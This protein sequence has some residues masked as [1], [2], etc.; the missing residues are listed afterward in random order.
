MVWQYVFLPKMFHWLISS[1]AFLEMLQKKKYETSSFRH[2]RRGPF[3]PYVGVSHEPLVSIDYNG[4]QNSATI[5][6]AMTSVMADRMVKVIAWYDNESGYSKRVVD[7]V[8]Y[9]AEKALS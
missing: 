1:L 5:D 9:V 8:E 7:L 2:R 4:N 6:L 3:A